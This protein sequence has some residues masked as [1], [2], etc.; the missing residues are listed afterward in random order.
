MSSEEQEKEEPAS[1][2][3][4]EEVVKTEHQYLHQR[5]REELGREP[6]EEELDE[7]LREHTEGY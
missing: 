5:L 6:T 4:L 7:W 3:E 2:P 1:S